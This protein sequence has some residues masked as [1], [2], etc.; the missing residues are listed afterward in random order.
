MRAPPPGGTL[1]RLQKSTSPLL[2]RHNV[3][4][5]LIIGEKGRDKKGNRKEDSHKKGSSPT[6]DI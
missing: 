3:E 6:Q 4:R 2:K 5:W 1:I